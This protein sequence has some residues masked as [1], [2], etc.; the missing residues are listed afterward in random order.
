MTEY[1]AEEYDKLYQKSLKLFDKFLTFYGYELSIECLE[2]PEFK[3]FKIAKDAADKY[4][5]EWRLS[6]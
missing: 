6:R 1:N 3:E 4:Y 5:E 2:L